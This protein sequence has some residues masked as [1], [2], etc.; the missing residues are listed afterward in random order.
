MPG[1]FTLTLALCPSPERTHTFTSAF[2]CNG[3]AGA[4]GLKRPQC[5]FHMDFYSSNQE[6]ACKRVT[7]EATVGLSTLH[8]LPFSYGP[9]VPG[10]TRRTTCLAKQAMSLG[11]LCELSEAP[12]LKAACPSLPGLQVW[13]R[14]PFPEPECSCGFSAV[15]SLSRRGRRP[16]SYLTGLEP[17]TCPAVQPRSWDFG[18][19]FSLLGQCLS[20]LSEVTV[21]GPRTATWPCLPWTGCCQGASRLL[22]ASIPGLPVSDSSWW[23][24]WLCLGDCPLG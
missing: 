6:L 8:P 20:T 9:G 1:V 7:A 12:G 13:S 16:R 3:V 15:G 17:V 24:C 5:L 21:Q 22:G 14:S 19:G 23:F 18:S 10:A 4:C 2:R 11:A